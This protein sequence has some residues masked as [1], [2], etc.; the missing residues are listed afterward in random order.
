MILGTMF[1]KAS[2]GT[3][4]YGWTESYVVPAGAANLPQAITSLFSLAQDRSKMCGAGVE[5]PYLR[6][7]DPDETGDSQVLPGPVAGFEV[8]QNPFTVIPVAA[9]S[10]SNSLLYN[11]QLFDAAGADNQL[12]RDVL[13]DM[14]WSAAIVRGEGGSSFKQRRTLW[15]RGNPDAAQDTSRSFPNPTGNPVAD[16]WLKKLQAF[17]TKLLAQG[18]GFRTRLPLAKFNVTGFSVI[19]GI[20]TFKIAGTGWVT[21]EKFTVKNM[22]LVNVL[23]SDV[24]KIKTGPYTVNTANATDVVVTGA[25]P[26]YTGWVVQQMGVAQK[27]TKSSVVF[28]NFVPRRYAKKDTGCPFDRPIVKPRR[29]R[30]TA[31]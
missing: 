2:V 31:A 7:S 9:N 26:D 19:G 11:R 4:A 24:V 12:K 27:V 23:T 25:Y 29:P 8:T 15:F 22:K 18:W 28:N 20:L 10:N 17:L 30:R 14:P 3:R 13:S 5:I 21:G 16:E 1:F 6:V